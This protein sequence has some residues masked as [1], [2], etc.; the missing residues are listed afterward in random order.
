MDKILKDPAI[1]EEAA[2]SEGSGYRHYLEMIKVLV[3]LRRKSDLEP[4]Q[5]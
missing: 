3:K 5:R 4:D 1:P 2:K